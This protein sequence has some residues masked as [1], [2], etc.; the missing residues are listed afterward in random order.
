MP[1]SKRC[2]GF[3]LLAAL[4]AAPACKSG[5]PTPRSHWSPNHW[6]VDSVGSRMAKHFT[7]YRKD[8]HGSF[9]DYQYRKKK[10]INQTLR[11]HFLN[12]NADSPFVPDDPS[13]TAPRPPHSIW[14]DPLSYIHAEG[15]A[16]GFVVLGWTGAYIPIPFDSVVASLTGAGDEF[17]EGSSDQ[18]EPP[19]VRKFKIKN[20]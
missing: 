4:L 5:L 11:R 16:L 10:S 3:V 15:L 1:T 2:L 20:R 14:P 19:P 6:T 9:V 18:R 12:N 17:F 7:G 13:Q 8:L